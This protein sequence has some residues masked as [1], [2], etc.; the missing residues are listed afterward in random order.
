MRVPAPIALIPALAALALLGGC[1]SLAA[2]PP[3]SLLLISSANQVPVDK[4]ASSDSASTITILVPAT[5]QALSTQRVPVLTGNNSV[6]YL[7]NALW[8]ELPA[9]LFA[10][11]LSDTI[12]AKTGRLVLSPSEALSD[13]GAHL[14]GELRN[15][16]ID[17]RTQMAV[18]TYDATLRRAPDKPFEKRRFEA[19]VA[20]DDVKP[21]A[22][23]AA[24]GRAAN[25][26]A[27]DVA[28]WIGN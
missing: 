13:P 15:F 4:P 6:A 26:V 24:I 14:T 20:V 5:P 12:T 27:D 23:A 3:E 2:K 22:A 25:R 11:L 21:T 1:I 7:K 16:S 28:A 19:T 10:R 8:S 18:V 17:E 9:R